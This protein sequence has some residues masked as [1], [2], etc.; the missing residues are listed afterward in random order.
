MNR[1]HSLRILVA[2]GLATVL[3]ASGISRAAAQNPTRIVGTDSVVVVPGEIYKAGSFHR[4]LLGSN[5]R[6]EWTTPIK[7]PVLNLRTFH[8]GLKPTKKG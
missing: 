6:D 4:A 7:V 3:V 2:T 8:G 1:S 5:Y